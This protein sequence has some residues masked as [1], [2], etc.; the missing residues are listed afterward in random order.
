MPARAAPTYVR[1]MRRKSILTVLVALLGLT[2]A[3]PATAA[4]GTSLPAGEVVCFLQYRHGIFVGER[5]IAFRPIFPDCIKCDAIVVD[6][7]V[8]IPL[9][10]RFANGFVLLDRAAQ[11]LDPASRAALR[12]AAQDNFMTVA[13]SAPEDITRNTGYVERASG[14][15]V[16]EPR[17]HLIEAS[18]YIDA[19]LRLLRVASPDPEGDP[20]REQ[21]MQNLTAAYGRMAQRR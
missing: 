5:C 7:G 3:T 9:L 18:A 19:G 1:A 20:S 11:T 13:L 4:P 8:S 17:Q 21:G 12:K 14:R 6:F 10:D 2:L 16:A 15:F